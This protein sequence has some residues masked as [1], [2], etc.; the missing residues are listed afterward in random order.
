M[1]LSRLNGVQYVRVAPQAIDALA[2]HFEMEMTE[3]DE[4]VVLLDDWPHT[5]QPTPLRAKDGRLI[6]GDPIVLD[7]TT[8]GLV[9]DGKE[10]ARVLVRWADIREIHVLGD[11][12]SRTA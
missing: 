8:D 3:R 9:F 5:I 1:D 10:S 6:A 12:V 11:Q 7:V 2:R 4:L